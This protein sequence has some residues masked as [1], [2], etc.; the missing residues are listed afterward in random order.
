MPLHSYFVLSAFILLGVSLIVIVLVSK[1]ED[2]KFLG[3]PTIDK[4][5]FISGKIALFISWGLFMNKA[6]FPK[7]GYI[8]VPAFL[9]WGATLLLWIGTGIVI[10]AFYSLG[11]SLKVGLPIE[12][13][14]LKT[15]GIYRFSRNPLYAGVC[16]INIAS[17]LYFPDLVNIVFTIFGLYIHHQIVIGEEKF[18]ESRFGSAWEEY[19]DKVRRYV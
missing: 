7:S 12:E 11:E 19:H 13:T 1:N 17:C 14:K 8:P 9:S 15:H 5:L 10:A 2:S 6:L 18:L 3:T 4:F 16:L